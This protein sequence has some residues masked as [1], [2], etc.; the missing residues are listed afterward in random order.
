MLIGILE[1]ASIASRERLVCRFE[2]RGSRGFGLVH[3][4][5]NFFFAPDS[6]GQ[7]NVRRTGS[8]NRQVS[9]V[10][11]ACGWPQSQLDPVFSLKEDDCSLFECLPNHSLCG[12]TKPV[13]IEGQRPIQ[14]IDAQGNDRHAWFHGGTLPFLS[15]GGDHGFPEAKVLAAEA[16]G[17]PAGQRVCPGGDLLDS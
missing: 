15:L 5:V 12:Q 4:Q 9:V 17:R 2:N 16:T 6:V 8:V 14:I 10:S 7:G 13:S 1:I 11:D 3:Q